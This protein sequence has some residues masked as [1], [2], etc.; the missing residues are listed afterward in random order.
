VAAR[1]EPVAPAPRGQAGA[2][3]L[4]QIGDTAASWVAGPVLVSSTRTAIVPLG[5]SGRPPVAMAKLPGTPGGATGQQREGRTLSVL[6][7]KPAVGDFTRYLPLR[8]IDGYVG[9]QPFVVERAMPGV[10]GDTVGAAV[11]DDALLRRWVDLR[12]DILARTTRRRAAVERL[13][14]RLHAAWARRHVE[15]GWVHGDFWPGN[16]L[17]DPATVRGGGIVDWEWAGADELPAQGD[18]SL[19]VL[20]VAVVGR[21]GR[22]P[23]PVAAAAGCGAWC[24]RSRH[25]ARPGQDVGVGTG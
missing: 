19:A 15:I 3:E 22:W 16:V 10:A 5:P 24:R 8:L 18:R 9:H 23:R 17:V 6:A 11:V 4:S 20:G 7:A 13:R 21:V 1:R 14:R 25:V 2:R 12:V